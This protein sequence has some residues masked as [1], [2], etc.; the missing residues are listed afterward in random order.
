[1]VINTNLISLNAAHAL[2]QSEASLANTI[3]ELSTGSKINSPMD[4]PAGLAVSTELSAQINRVSAASTNL[5]NA[6]SFSQ[7]Q[8]GYLQQVSSALNQM[9]QLTIQSQDVTKSNADRTLYQA[10]FAKLGSYVNDI[11]TKDF[12]GVSLFNGTTLNVTTDSEG[13][14]VALAGANL[15]AA[16]YTT[17]TGS[18]VDTTAHA[19][20]ALANVEAAITQLSS[21]QANIGA[22]QTVMTSYN[23]T[24]SALQTNLT[25]AN[26]QIMDVDVATASTQYARFNILVQSGTAM[27]AQ[28]NQVP[29]SVLKLIGG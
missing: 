29:Q 8:D 25:A 23:N 16:A 12:N 3:Q 4:D 2:G 11:A 14:T 15:G 5:T 21:D 26:S 13:H 28:A 19:A 10:E 6:L 1:M 18:M 17:A 27:L 22:N 7:T 24:L 9:S 20:T